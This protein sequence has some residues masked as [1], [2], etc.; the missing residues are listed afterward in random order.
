MFSEKNFQFQQGTIESQYLPVV[1]YIFVFFQFQQ[2]TIESRWQEAVLAI[3]QQAFNSNKVR[4]RAA[5][6]PGPLRVTIFSFNSNKVR[7]RVLPKDGAKSSAEAFQ[8]QQGT[9]ERRI[10][11]VPCSHWKRTFNSNK[12][13]LRVQA[14]ARRA[15][16]Y[17]AFQFQQGTIE[18]WGVDGMDKPNVSTFNSN[19]VRLRVCAPCPNCES[20][21]F[22][23]IPTRYD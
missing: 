1:V 19:K 12:V 21:V 4:L 7:L 10:G 2:G 17:G 5:R 14:W 13:R 23:S 22:L 18:S 8:F 11:C 20:S 16:D 9:I 15:G 3:R 6:R